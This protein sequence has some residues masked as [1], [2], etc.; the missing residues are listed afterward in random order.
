MY[1]LTSN[2]SIVEPT[3]QFF[4][5]N[6]PFIEV[7]INKSRKTLTNTAKFTLPR[8]IGALE[9]GK[10]VDINSMLQ[11]GS[12]VKMQIGYDGNL[13]TEFTGYLSSL[14]ADMPVEVFCQD[15]MW[16]L[17]QNSFTKNWGKA[18][19][20]ADI[21]GDIYTGKA[22][23][24]DLSI[25]GLLVVKQSTAQILEGLKK[26]GLQC[27]FAPDVDGNNTLYVDFAGAIHPVNKEVIYGI[28]QNVIKT[29]LTYK[30]KED[31]L[32]Q[33]VGVSKL[34]NGK[35]I[36]ITVGDNGGEIHTLHYSNM[37]AD[38][39]QKVVN[40]EIDKLK[41]NGYKGTFTTWGVPYIEPGYS[42]YMQDD[43]Y[44]ERDGIYLV[45]T[46]KTTFGIKGFRRE[47]ELERKLA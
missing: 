29:E 23:V 17:K 13:L 40:A 46:V 16:K 14:G 33:V 4:V 34:P 26:F 35:K 36:Q 39:L 8:N 31:S 1:R 22:A 25:G 11:R 10:R 28:Y 5:E 12:Q 32:I 42:A 18:T 27:Y 20:I 47:I 30:R 43:L 41:Y 2:I 19:K 7:V 9:A 44:P 21:V 15:E 24:V 37:D 6:I 38:Q 45:E 3:G